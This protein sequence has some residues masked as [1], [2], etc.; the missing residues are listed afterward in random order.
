MVV[1]I[2]YFLFF[3]VLRLWKKKEGKCMCG[4]R[5]GVY[6]G[7]G[8]HNPMSPNRLGQGSKCALLGARGASAPPAVLRQLRVLRIPERW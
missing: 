6:V 7:T 5:G 8:T 4:G 2:F 3:D 1:D